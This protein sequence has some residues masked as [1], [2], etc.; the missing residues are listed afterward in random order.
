MPKR[1]AIISQKNLV[2]VGFFLFVG[3]AYLSK[4]LYPFNFSHVEKE[5]LYSWWLKSLL[6]DAGIALIAST[7]IV[8]GFRALRS[9]GRSL[10]RGLM[11]G[12]GFGICILFLIFNFVTYFQTGKILQSSNF[13][14]VILKIEKMLEQPDI[15]EHRRAILLRKL[16]ESRYIQTGELMEILDRDGKKEL[17]RPP[18]EMLRFKRQNDQTRQ[19]LGWVKGRA[20]VSIF[21]WVGIFFISIIA[22]IFTPIKPVRIEP[23]APEPKPGSDSE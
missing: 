22:G 20:L 13:R 4:T 6:R 2:A 9:E 23:A 17:F 18:K 5:I 10:S 3:G 16:A 7:I 21:F 1:K 8:G 15:A 19:L 11:V 14:D 12:T